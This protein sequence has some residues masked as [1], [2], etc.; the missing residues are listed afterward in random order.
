MH[1]SGEE[2]HLPPVG[3]R[4]PSNEYIIKA[5]NAISVNNIAISPNYP[6][7][8]LPYTHEFAFEFDHYTLSNY[9]WPIPSDVYLQAIFDALSAGWEAIVDDV[10][11]FRSY[12]EER[13]DERP[14]HDGYRFVSRG[15]E[16]VMVP[17]PHG[18][19][20]ADWRFLLMAF[21][22]IVWLYEV[23]GFDFT[24][25]DGPVGVESERGI[26]M[27]GSMRFVGAE[28]TVNSASIE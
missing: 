17:G 21:T 10:E 7:L 4:Q 14:Y 16:F 1:R 28:K 9:R 18:V 27:T 3:H 25:W 15:V 8:P 5:R 2:R 20:Y 12:A 26:M 13:V 6:P 11:D 24:A 23:H 22:D 19:D